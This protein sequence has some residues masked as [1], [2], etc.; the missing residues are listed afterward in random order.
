MLS[1][2]LNLSEVEA[3]TIIDVLYGFFHRDF[4]AAKTYLAGEIYIN[5]RSHRKHDGKELDFWHLTTKDVKEQVWE[6]GKRIWRM[7]GRYPDFDRASRLEWVKQI[8]TNHTHESVRLFYHQE[9]NRKRD[10][11][12]YLWA[13]KDDFVVILQ[14]LGKSSSFLVTSFYIT[15]E[16]K[17]RDFEKRYKNYCRGDT[18]L[19]GCE[20]F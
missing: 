4:V 10:I 13:Y 9:T 16:G 6:N 8:L 2:P 17:R 20:W 19:V 1:D 15:H 11:R 3:T 14:K 18:R 7:T 5:P 12:L